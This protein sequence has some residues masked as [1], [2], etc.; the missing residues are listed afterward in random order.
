MKTIT[1]DDFPSF[2]KDND[3]VVLKF[4][5][6]WCAPCRA[7]TP[8]M[9]SLSPQFA[10][11]AFAE[12]DVDVSPNLAAQFNIRNVPTVVGFKKGE[13]QWMKVGLPTPSDLR[14][15]LQSLN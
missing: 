11:I 2:V 14:N 15:T 1:Q 7:F 4:S 3:L 10:E 8:M 6:P 5:A 9:E 12:V 13:V